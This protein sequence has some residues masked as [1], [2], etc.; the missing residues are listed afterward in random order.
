MITMAAVYDKARQQMSQL[1]DGVCTIYG[2]QVQKT[3]GVCFGEFW[4]PLD[5]WLDL[6]CHLAFGQNVPAK[7]DAAADGSGV[8]ARFQ[9][10]LPPA[11][12]GRVLP[13]GSRVRVEQWGQVYWLACSGQTAC[14]PTHMEVMVQLLDE[15]A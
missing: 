5:G 4:Q 2:L 14:Y 11:E 6:P 8:E 10:F 13:A 15:H 7:T 1:L 3:A 12:P 9:L